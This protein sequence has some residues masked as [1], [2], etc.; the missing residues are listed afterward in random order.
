M[1]PLLLVAL[2]ALAACSD[3][4]DP[5]A[6]AGSPPDAAPA[7]DRAVG[8]DLGDSAPGL[9]DAASG[10]IVST[11]SG[12]VRGT[13]GATSRVF[14][15]VP[16]AAP[17]VGALRFAAPKAPPTW[18]APRTSTTFGPG[19]PQVL[20]AMASAV[21][22]GKIGAF[23]QSEDC[24]TL[25]VWTPWPAPAKPAP[26]LVWIHGGGF[27]SGAASLP[28]IAPAG[29][30]MAEKTGLVV[31]SLNY[32]LG[33]L[34]FLA[35]PALGK[36]SGNYGVLDQQAA[37]A[38]VKQ[39]IAAFG[40]DPKRVT[41]A[42]ESAG[43]FSVCVHL[44]APGSKGLFHR[45]VMQSGA[46]PQALPQNSTVVTQKVAMDQGKAVAQKVGCATAADVAAC[47]RKASVQKL[48]AALPVVEDFTDTTTQG[49]GWGPNTDGV[50]LGG[51]PLTLV[52]AKTFH[53]VPVLL[54]TNRDEGTVLVV[55]AKKT[56]LTQGQYLQLVGKM[57]SL[58]SGMVLLNYPAVSYASPAAALAALMGDLVFVCPARRTARALAAAGV[59]TYL[60]TFTVQ[61]SYSAK[62]P[63]L[64]SYHTAE[65]PFV[66]ATPPPSLAFNAK[67]AALATGMLGYWT[68][69][70]R[71]G[72]PN[73]KGQVVWPTFAEATDRHMAFG[74][75]G[76]KT[77]VGLR[78]KQ[79]DFW[80]TLMN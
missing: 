50:T 54:G 46:C 70:A 9:P 15:G 74:L 2:L 56:G 14:L 28:H 71:L 30:V 31:V 25:N 53:K 38:W 3:A 45:A 48:L 55:A 80:D 20:S 22:A 32:R 4:A 43:A 1:R 18:T 24:L 76:V 63:F 12:P 35:H 26:V 75:S 10:A 58:I 61:P 69:F 40:G 17:P 34:G 5:D 79:C 44:V 16:Y 65:V 6:D 72:D 57:F 8:A 36:A 47:L 49:A 39:N 78:K 19:C 21:P 7:P 13:V 77:G 41:I 23:T 27:T 68:R 29:Q 59:K 52:R 64:G 33:P 62:A 51:Q 60:Y 11:I 37:L 66:F 42:G 73:I 67:E